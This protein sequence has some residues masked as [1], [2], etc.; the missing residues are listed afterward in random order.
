MGRLV[1]MKGV[2]KVI[3]NLRRVHPGTGQ[4][5]ARG[6]K[7]AGLFVQRESQK[8]VPVDTAALKNSAFTRNIGGEGFDVD[9][10]VGY[11]QGYAVYVHENLDAQHK[12]GKQAKYL[13]APVRTNKKEILQIIDKG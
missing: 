2:K 9:V 5:V 3:R 1:Q 8:V 7:R 6:I 11:T 10:I 13:E 4:K 12:E